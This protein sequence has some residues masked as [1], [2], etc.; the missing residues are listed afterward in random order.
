MVSNRRHVR[1]WV[2]HRDKVALHVRHQ[3]FPRDILV[4][5][6]YSFMKNERYLS[7]YFGY[8]SYTTGMQTIALF[9]LKM[10]RL[11]ALIGAVTWFVLCVP[12]MSSL[13]DVMI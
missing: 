13:L 1:L 10:K 2:L 11:P 7:S 3:R 4:R 12:T 6:R 9:G 5:E 8:Y